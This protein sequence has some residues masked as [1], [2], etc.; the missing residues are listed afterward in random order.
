[1][2]IG[3]AARKQAGS[4]RRRRALIN[5]AHEDYKAP[6]AR[7][8]P[9]LGGDGQSE[10]WRKRLRDAG[11]PRRPRWAHLPSGRVRRACYFPFAS[12]T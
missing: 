9:I 7:G 10:E 3:P 2:E 1:M 11:P 6:Y 12:S 4:R 5:L 8:T